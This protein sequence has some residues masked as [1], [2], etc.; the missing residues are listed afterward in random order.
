MFGLKAVN[1]EQLDCHQHLIHLN[2]K[3]FDSCVS[4][5]PV[6]FFRFDLNLALTFGRF[7][8]FCIGQY[9]TDFSF[10]DFIFQSLNLSKELLLW[11]L[12]LLFFLL[13][14]FFQFF[15]L[16]LDDHLFVQLL[17][18]RKMVFFSI[19]N[20]SFKGGDAFL[21]IAKQLK[22]LLSFL[23]ILDFKLNVRLQ[24]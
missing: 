21:I 10:R 12:L 23:V 8:L 7:L 19:N 22:S 13:Y 24:Q 4:L 15:G 1:F 2:F 18:L 20:K 11:F 5:I 6:S 3:L 14:F 16:V 9:L 17:F